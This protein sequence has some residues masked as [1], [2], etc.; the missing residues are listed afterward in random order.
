MHTTCRGGT[1]ASMRGNHEG[2]SSLLFVLGRSLEMRSQLEALHQADSSRYINSIKTDK[3]QT[4][5]ST[6]EIFRPVVQRLTATALPHFLPPHAR[7]ERDE[8]N[9]LWEFLV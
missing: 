5:T 3:A 1:Y 7:S 4:E 9:V 8:D 6:V 2:S